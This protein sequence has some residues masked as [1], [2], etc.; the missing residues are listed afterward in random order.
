MD[1]Q[2]TWVLMTTVRREIL[3]PAEQGG[4]RADIA[5]AALWPDFSR[6]R[7]QQW[8]RSGRITVDGLVLRPRDPLAPGAKAVLDAVLEPVGDDEP[9]PIPLA[10]VHEDEAILVV[11]KPAGLVV[12]PGAGNRA[13]TLV[14]ALLHRAPGLINL[15]RAGLVHR[16][17]KDTSGLLVIG[18]TVAAHT[19]L[20]EMMQAREIGREYRAVVAG[21]PTG[22]GT[23]DE[24]ISRHTTDRT[25]MAVREGGRRAVTHFRVLERFRAHSYLA[26]ELETGRTHQIRVHLTHRRLPIVGDPVYGRRRILPKEPDAGLIAAL[27]D[28]R[29]QALHAAR[30][31]FPHPVGGTPMVFEAPLPADLSR[32]LDAMRADADAHR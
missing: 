31:A 5:L 25:R 24:P 21:V 23:I 29:R 14:N 7:I 8:I 6:A 30:L 1:G 27:Q 2:D 19:R 20:V 12:H 28:F 4:S 17:D 18:K 22:G 13:G 15:P 9:E 11:D 10:V 3:I 32:L 26:V 16:L